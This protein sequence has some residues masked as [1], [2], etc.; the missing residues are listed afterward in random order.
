MINKRLV[1]IPSQFPISKITTSF[2]N[3]FDP[4][5]I[6]SRIEVE[7]L[8]LVPILE[9]TINKIKDNINKMKN[10]HLKSIASATM[11]LS[12]INFFD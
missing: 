12:A 11:D 4:L 10:N 6:N 2:D 3:F 1:K 9:K 5:S 7:K 8:E